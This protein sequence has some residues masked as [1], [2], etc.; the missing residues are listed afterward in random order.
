[1]LLHLLG[2]WLHFASAIIIIGFFSSLSLHFHRRLLFCNSLLSIFFYCSTRFVPSFV[3]CNC[4]WQQISIVIYSEW[5]SSISMTT[6][7]NKHHIFPFSFFFLYFFFF[8]FDFFFS[9]SWLWCHRGNPFTLNNR[10]K[11]FHYKAGDQNERPTDWSTDRPTQTKRRLFLSVSQA[12]FCQ[13]CWS[14]VWTIKV[15]SVKWI[16]DWMQIV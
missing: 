4:T 13:F 10:L 6:T 7:T 3:Q 15:Q 11:H 16:D 1:M 5:L 2:L 12:I 8:F 9:S 14:I